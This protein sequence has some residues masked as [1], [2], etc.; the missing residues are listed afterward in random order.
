MAL[1]TQKKLQGIFITVALTLLTMLAV[2]K[3]PF[4]KKLIGG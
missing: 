2:N 4:L 3:V 1:V